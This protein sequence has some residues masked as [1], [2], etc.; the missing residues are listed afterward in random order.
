MSQ[1]QGWIEQECYRLKSLLNSHWCREREKS[2]WSMS[3]KS[4]PQVHLWLQPQIY[5]ED[6]SMLAFH[7]TSQFFI[8]Y[9]VLLAYPHSIGME[10]IPRQQRYVLRPPFVRSRLKTSQVMMRN[11]SLTFAMFLYFDDFPASPLIIVEHQA[12]C[13][14][15]GWGFPENRT[16]QR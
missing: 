10:V 5:F 11:V 6:V 3:M 8:N 16:V 12:C 13:A 14:W 15:G 9:S 2:D 4:L 1:K 7:E